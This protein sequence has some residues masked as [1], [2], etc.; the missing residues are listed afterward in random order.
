MHSRGA[1]LMIRENQTIR[2][3]NILPPARRKN[4]NLRNIIRRQRLTTRINSIRLTL[5]P[6]KPHNTK[7]SFNL[8]GINTNDSHPRRDELF[9]QTVGERSDGCFGRA[10]NSAAGI[11]LAACDRPD[12][13]DVACSCAVVALEH[14]LQDFLGHVDQAGD[15]GGEHDGHVGFGDFGSACDAFYKASVVMLSAAESSGSFMFEGK[16]H[17]RIIHQHIDLLELAWKLA[18]E[19]VDFAG[20]ADV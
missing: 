2:H 17:S 1:S 4:H 8:S 10:V 14:S 15:V 5:I 7:L 16:E 12:V 9:P 11:R 6:I 20:L 18:H 19:S 3:N 13:D